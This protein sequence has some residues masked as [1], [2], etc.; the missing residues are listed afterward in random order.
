[1]PHVSPPPPEQAAA[2]SG[3][4]IKIDNY[5]NYFIYAY[6]KELY[7]KNSKKSSKYKHPKIYKN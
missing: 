3:V 2:A 5:K 6:N 1:M 4:K 7:K